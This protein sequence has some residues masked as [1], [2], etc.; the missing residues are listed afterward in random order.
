M[1]YELE[2]KRQNV[3]SVKNPSPAETAQR[4]QTAQKQSLMSRDSVN[5]LAQRNEQIKQMVQNQRN[6]GKVLPVQRQMNQTGNPAQ[7]TPNRNFSAERDNLMERARQLREGNASSINTP[8]RAWQAEEAQTERVQP[9]AYQPMEREQ[10]AERI[11]EPERKEAGQGNAVSPDLEE[12]KKQAMM[13]ADFADLI[14]RAQAAGDQ[15]AVNH[16]T[17]LRNQKLS[18]MNQEQEEP[19]SYNNKDYTQD[20]QAMIQQAEA[21]GNQ[22]LKAQLE[23]DRQAK[24]D[25]LNNTDLQALIDEANASGDSAAAD[26][27]G[28]LRNQ[29]LAMQQAQPAYDAQ[30]E[31]TEQPEYMNYLTNYKGMLNATTDPERR[32]QLEAERQKKTEW[33]MNN[34]IQAMIDAET[35]PQRK[36]ALEQ[37]RSEKLY[38]MENPEPE[39]PLDF[40][41]DA[42]NTIGDDSELI[43]QEY[44]DLRKEAKGYAKNYEDWADSQLTNE[45]IQ[46]QIKADQAIKE[47]YQR[48]N[49]QDL[50]AL[51]ERIANMGGSSSS[52]FSRQENLMAQQGIMSERNEITMEQNRI[53]AEA[54][55]RA[56]ELIA[57]GRIKE[58]DQMIQIGQNRANALMQ[59]RT[60]SKNLAMQFANMQNE[61][62]QN[63]INRRFTTSEREASQQ[64]Q[65]GE[66]EKQ[67]GWESG[68][69]QA[70]R[71]WQSGENKLGREHETSE[72]LGAQEFTTG[73]DAKLYEYDLGK[74]EKQHIYNKDEASHS[75]AVN[76]KYR[77]SGGGRSSSNKYAQSAAAV[78][79]L[80]SSLTG[81]PITDMNELYNNKDNVIAGLVGSGMTYSQAKSEYAG[82]VNNTIKQAE[83]VETNGEG[84]DSEPAYI[85]DLRV[86]TGVSR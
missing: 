76:A 46:A 48:Y 29:K 47:L 49:A 65:A 3:Q 39:S 77:S 62:Q 38:L 44:G 56:D 2:K 45:R 83:I 12:Q 73:R 26:Y 71:D 32:A 57:Q 78:A 85:Q 30:P 82:M 14:Q 61:N 68:E 64:F 33:L 31:Q 11:V 81:N 19:R 1:V 25:Y 22:E 53:M 9:R 58:A 66:S 79:A 50:P 86:K 28:I 23:A 41:Q 20:F 13:N 42:R 51:Q 69:N 54:Q 27:Y 24:I 7:R 70:Q 43:K 15:D 75:A 55:A 52:G 10:E 35:D 67:R 5:R 84:W 8:K 37:L 74:M 4:T 80:S 59:D 6:G 72:R 34:D 17:E 40:Y 60:N 36:A 16:Y 18:M 21:D 63:D